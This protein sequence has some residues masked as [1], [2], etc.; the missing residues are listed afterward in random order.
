M[1]HDIKELA[2]LK[3]QCKIGNIFVSIFQPDTLQFAVSFPKY[4]IET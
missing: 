3:L 2:I 1:I 4:K